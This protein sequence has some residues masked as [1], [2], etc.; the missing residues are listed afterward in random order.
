MYCSVLDHCSTP[1]IM[2]QTLG[3]PPLK[4]ILD[5]HLNKAIYFFVM[6]HALGAHFVNLFVRSINGEYFNW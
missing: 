1:C 5:P 3:V 6:K 2:H 4:Q